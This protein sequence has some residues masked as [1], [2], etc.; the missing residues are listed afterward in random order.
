[1]SC[2][3]FGF[4]YSCRDHLDRKAFWYSCRD[5]LD[6]KAFW[7][8]YRDHLDRKAFCACLSSYCL[9]RQDDRTTSNASDN[10]KIFN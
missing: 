7:Y 1:M 4:E 3:G 2:E 6:R 9:R 8:S 10:G 5:H